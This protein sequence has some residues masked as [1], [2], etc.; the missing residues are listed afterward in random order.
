MRE[1]TRLRALLGAAL[2]VFAVLLVVA[3]SIGERSVP[4]VSPATAGVPVTDARVATPAP[5]PPTPPPG[6]SRAA[7]APGGIARTMP[8]P[9]SQSSAAN[10]RRRARYPRSSYPLAAAEGD[11]IAREREVTPITARGPNGAE[12]TLTVF[13]AQT[14]FE[15]PDPVPLY[16]S[17]SIRER[18]VGAREIRATI[19]T[20]TL[21][22]VGT[23]EY[24]DDGTGAD[25][26]AGDGVYSALF[27][28]PAGDALAT[29]YLAQVRALTTDGEERFGAT[30]F[31]YSRPHAQLTGTFRDALVDG[32]LTVDVEL[33]VSTPGR[34]HVEATL[35]DR[36]GAQALV[37][38]QAAARLD[39]G[40]HWLRLPFYGLALREHG[41]DGP[42]LLRYVA[43]ST[44]TA[45]PNAKNRVL[46]NAHL[47]PAYRATA[48][49]AA[50][51]DDPD[52]LDA[53]TRLERDGMPRGLDAG[54]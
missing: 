41:V 13:P 51:F 42:Y 37:W 53:A 9:P 16:A 26:E 46:E 30:S 19:V 24:V 27:Q 23:I 40:R 49:T 15:A 3:S 50:P 12:P 28:P 48:F 44:T 21:A 6:P 18:L 1:H 10:Y 54:G 7:P 14:G 43:L 4:Q 22:P 17:L 11:P 25:A 2:A 36:D 32:S 35:Y 29:S 38:A 34:F 5:A 47:T 8:V 33:D 45:M 39:P 52:L 31:L 20:D